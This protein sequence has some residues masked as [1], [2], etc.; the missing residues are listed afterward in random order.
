MMRQQIRPMRFFPFVGPKRAPR[1]SLSRFLAF[2]AVFLIVPDPQRAGPLSREP[3]VGAVRLF[4]APE[5]DLSRIDI[6][7]VNAAR[8]EIDLAAYVLTDRQFIDAL[9]R[10][11]QRGVRVRLYLHPEQPGFQSNERGPFRSLITTPGITVRFKSEG[12]LMHLKSYQVDRQRL[13]TG[14]TNFSFTGLRRQDNDL[15]VIDSVDAVARFVTFFDRVWSRPDNA[16]IQG[17]L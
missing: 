8:R 14:S 9:T 11:A 12:D 13:R 3:I 5:Q 7:I 15:I 10:A 2:L 6:D 4:Y 16:S 1:R 17:H